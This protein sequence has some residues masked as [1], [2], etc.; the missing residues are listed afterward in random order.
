MNTTVKFRVAQLKAMHAFML[1]ANDE[2]LYYKWITLAVPDEPT[3]ED[4]V[5]IAEDKDFYQEC[6]DVFT[7]IVQSKEWRA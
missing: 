3:E 1:T 4:F 2:E 6:C 5:D 7:R